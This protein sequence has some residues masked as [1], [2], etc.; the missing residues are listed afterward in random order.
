MALSFDRVAPYYDWLARAVLGKGWRQSQTAF[1]PA[2]KNCSSILI[3]GG[4]TGWWLSTLRELN[5]KASI[6]FVDASKAMVEKARARINDRNVHFVVATHEQVPAKHYEAIVLFYFLDLFDEGSLPSVLAQLKQ[7]TT[8]SALWLVS[9]FV[10][11][12]LWQRMLLAVMYTFFGI[13]TGLTTTRLPNWR[14]NLHRAGLRPIDSQTFGAGFMTA[15][16]W[17][18][19]TA[20]DQRAL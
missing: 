13:A 8:N 17:F 6:T 2:L 1:L 12:R 18:V 20:N 7:H 11:D 3:V 19:Q 15:S 5:P 16:V 14:A 9:D 4:G 10:G